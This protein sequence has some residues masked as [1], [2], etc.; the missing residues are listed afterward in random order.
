[1]TIFQIPK[2]KS[3]IIAE[4][5]NTHT[6]SFKKLEKIV[7][8]TIQTKTDAIKFQFFNTSDLLVPNHPEYN[9]FKSLEFSNLQWKKIF[10]H[11]KKY[12]IK[13]CVD[14]FSIN[15]AKFANKL[16][17]DIFKI[18]SSDIGNIDLLK[19]LAS[20]NKPIIL[21]CSGCKI[22]EI[23]N[24][25]QILK[26]NGKSQIILMHGFQGFPT[27]ISDIN[28]DRIKTFQTLYDL[29]IGYSDHVSGDSD[30]GTYFPL[31]ALGKGALII[32]KH[33]TLERRLKEEDY[34]SSINPDEFKKFVN[35]IKNSIKG[36]GNPSLKIS[37]S[38][39]NYRKRMKRI[40]VSRNNLTKNHKIKYSDISLKRLDNYHSGLSVDKLIDGITRT[41]ISK[42]FELYEKNIKINKTKIAAVLACRIESRRLFAKPLQQIGNSTILKTLILQLKQSKLIDEIVLAISQNPGNEVFVDFA[43][44]NN[45]KFVLGDD[46]D[47]QKRIIDAADLVQSDI[48]FRVTTEDPFVYWE[49]IDS[50][51][52]QHISTNVDLTYVP[53]LPEGTGFELISIL[54]L[55]KSHKCGNKK[56]RSEL[57]TEYMHQN[58]H[59]F[60]FKPFNVSLEFQRPEIRLSVDNPEDLILVKKIFSELNFEKKIP[61]LKNILKLLDKKPKL[62]EIN[63]EFVDQ[64]YRNWV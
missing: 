19:Y 47:V 49:I 1:M 12:K 31:I 16:G 54:A 13:I 57:V 8:Q 5:A 45:L 52:K 17:T 64:S 18:H 51:I 35:I 44:K 22:N 63:K 60:K 29:P 48:I 30:F 20:T 38:E 39:L 4:I 26:N 36:I 40:P 21:S 59:Q 14:V 15:K 7:N 50:A 43:Q 23:D 27:K 6:G 32:E 42:N 34:E 10:K 24:A 53:N 9:L 2:K 33:V 62:L 25:I 11:L 61:T 55:K 3:F 46:Q 28:L 58:R 56:T 37:G 41:N